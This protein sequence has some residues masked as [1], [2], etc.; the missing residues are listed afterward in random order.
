MLYFILIFTSLISHVIV[1]I[2]EII[3]Y[4]SCYSLWRW[5]LIIIFILI[6]K[7]WINKRRIVICLII[8]RFIWISTR[9]RQYMWLIHWIIWLI[10]INWVSRNIYC[11]YRIMWNLIW[12]RW[13]RFSIIV[14]LLTYVCLIYHLYILIFFIIQIRICYLCLYMI[15]MDTIVYIRIFI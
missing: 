8:S 10:I 13:C 2:R 11:I 15:G 9:R 4:L 14:I 7:I 5:F 12:I 1:P 3:Y 6:I